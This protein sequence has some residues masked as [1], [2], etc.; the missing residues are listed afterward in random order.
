TMHPECREGLK[1][2][3]RL[4]QDLGHELVESAPTVSR[5]EFQQAFVTMLAGE[6]AS[7]LKLASLHLNR[8]LKRTDFEPA[9]LALARLGKALNAEEVGVAR[10][11]FGRLTRSIGHWFANYDVFL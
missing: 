4:L 2:T 7:V 9:T 5:D 8:P 1:R 10:H 11:Y 6:I 3:V